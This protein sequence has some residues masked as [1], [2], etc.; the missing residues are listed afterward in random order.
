M[1]RCRRGAPSYGQGDA[2]RRQRDR[3]PP[4]RQWAPL[5]AGILQADLRLTG[6]NIAYPAW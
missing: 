3:A 6:E 2:P 1:R 4:L 5:L